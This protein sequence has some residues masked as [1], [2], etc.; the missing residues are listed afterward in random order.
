MGVFYGFAACCLFGVVFRSTVSGA[1]VG[2]GRG[3]SQKCR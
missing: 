2:A 1:G 3:H